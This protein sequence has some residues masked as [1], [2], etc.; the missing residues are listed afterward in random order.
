MWLQYMIGETYF[1]DARIQTELELITNNEKECDKGKTDKFEPKHKIL[2]K[3][4][5]SKKSEKCCT[6]A[7]YGTNQ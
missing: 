1:K 6:L 5:F 3:S 2:I 7:E 4:V